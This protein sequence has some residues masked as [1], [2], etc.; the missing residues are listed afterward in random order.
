MSP[1]NE[2]ATVILIEDDPAVCEALQGLFE[3]VGLR[4]EAFAS[5]HEFIGARISEGPGCMVLDVRLPGLNGLDFYEGLTPIENRRPAVFISGHADVRMS[6]RAMKA[7]AVEFLAK[8]VRD[9]ELLDAVQLAIA[10]DRVQ[11]VGVMSNAKVS[12]NFADLTQRERE[13]MASV[14][15]GRK[16]KEIAAELGLSEA[17]VKLHR[18]HVMQKM[19]AQSL[20]ELVRMSDL[21]GARDRKP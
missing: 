18:G 17:T 15:A 11:R 20:A 8:P 2:R 1:E 7:G 5:S 4:V 12:R 21:L 14:V 19:E 16:N 10:R 3:S 13:V 6:V 9:Q